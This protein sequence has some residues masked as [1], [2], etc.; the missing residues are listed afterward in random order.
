LVHGGENYC[1]PTLINE[2]V[3]KSINDLSRLAPLHNPANLVGINASEAVFS[4]LPQVA[5]FDTA[6]HHT[7]PEKAYLYGIP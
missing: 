2:D 7:M 6:F 5:I 3:K 4:D 1:T